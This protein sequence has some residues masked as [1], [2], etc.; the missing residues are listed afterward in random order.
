MENGRGRRLLI[1]GAGLVVSCA[2]LGIG[3]LLFGSTPQARAARAL[4]VPLPNSRISVENALPGTDTWASVG[5]YN[6]TQFAAFAGA[7][8]VNAGDAIDIHVTSQAGTS[9]SA[10]LYRLGYYQD[11]GARVITTTN[12]IPITTH[13]SGSTCPYD[14]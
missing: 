9:L 14:S 1:V 11:H 12:N 7:T 13:V 5:N 4:G 8:S 3:V 10:V 6:N 2:L